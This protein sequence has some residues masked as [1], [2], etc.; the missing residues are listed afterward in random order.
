MHVYP[1]KDALAA[2]KFL[3]DP[4][5]KGSFPQKDDQFGSVALDQAA[6][7]AGAV[8]KSKDKKKGNQSTIDI[9]W[10]RPALSINLSSLS[11]VELKKDHK[12]EMSQRKH[13]KHKVDNKRYST[14]PNQL[15]KEALRALNQITQAGALKF[16]EKVVLKGTDEFTLAEWSEYLN[17][18]L[19]QIKVGK[20]KS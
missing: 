17:K 7:G 4:S 8:N 20:E 13:I 2:N 1:F 19:E 15:S 6:T 16:Q 5:N 9:E 12:I 3:V 18:H 10:S 11:S 14:G